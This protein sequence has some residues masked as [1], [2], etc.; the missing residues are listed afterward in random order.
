MFL[1]LGL[2]PTLAEILPFVV[3]HPVRNSGVTAP[4][5]LLTTKLMSRFWRSAQNAPSRLNLAR[6]PISEKS[7]LSLSPG[8]Q[9]KLSVKLYAKI[10]LR[11]ILLL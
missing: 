5:E 4:R 6:A 3:V 10:K 11:P 2:S 8:I 9:S 7:F 1:H